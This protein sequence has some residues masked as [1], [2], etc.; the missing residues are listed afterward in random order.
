MK[1][2]DDKME[3]TCVVKKILC[4]LQKKFHYMM[5]AIEESQNMNVFSIQGLIGKLQA[6]KKRVN[7]IQEDMGTQSLFSKHDGS[8]YFLGDW[9]RGQSKEREERDR[10]GR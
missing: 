3:E 2:Y 5:V 6:N 1:R 9:G 8:R 4:L 10:F 7:E